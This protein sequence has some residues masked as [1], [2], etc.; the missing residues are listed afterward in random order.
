MKSKT[1]WKIFFLLIHIHSIHSNCFRMLTLWV[2]RRRIFKGKTTLKHFCEP[3]PKTDVHA[4]HIFNW[5]NSQIF[6]YSVR[7]SE[8]T[9]QSYNLISLTLL[10]NC[11]T[12]DNKRHS[13][14]SFIAFFSPRYIPLS[15]KNGLDENIIKKIYINSVGFSIFFS[16][17][18][19]LLA[20]FNATRSSCRFS[21][22]MLQTHSQSK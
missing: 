4:V 19:S 3:S 12:M 10:K 21:V 20:N 16:L 22:T 9:K 17:S 11:K 2:E 18:L 6:K 8:W 7:T 14:F 1:E 13:H 5:M 15:T